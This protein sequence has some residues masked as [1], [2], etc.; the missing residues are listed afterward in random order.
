MDL[1]PEPNTAYTVQ[2]VS[3]AANI[4]ELLQ[5]TTVDETEHP[6]QLFTGFV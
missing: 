2:Q 1:I 3:N 4:C 6:A 5:K